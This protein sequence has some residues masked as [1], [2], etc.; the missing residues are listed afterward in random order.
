[1]S[2]LVRAESGRGTKAGHCGTQN[3]R[4]LRK[5]GKKRKVF[6]LELLQKNS[7]CRRYP[8]GV[9]RRY[10][11]FFQTAGQRCPRFWN[12]RRRRGDLGA[13]PRAQPRAP[14]QEKR[15]ER[16][17]PVREALQAEGAKQVPEAAA[18]CSLLTEAAPFWGEAR[19]RQGESTFFGR[20]GGRE[21]RDESAAG[22]SRA[23]GP[24]ARRAA[25]AW[26]QTALRREGQKDAATDAPAKRLPRQGVTLRQGP[27][28]DAFPTGACPS[29]SCGERAECSCTPAGCRF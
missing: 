2:E 12:G 5:A 9:Q 11:P 3:S 15:K 27:R 7:G 1:M 8:Q 16:S 24:D 6:S 26:A 19:T 13:F 25:C 17:C 4:V 21:G 10:V 20:G 14:R 22:F 29:S 28:R 18:P 23:Q